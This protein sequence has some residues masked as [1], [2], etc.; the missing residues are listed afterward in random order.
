[1][2][3]QD[4]QWVTST[5]SLCG[6]WC[7]S[8]IFSSKCI[9]GANNNVGVMLH[10]SSL[11]RMRNVIYKVKWDY[12]FHLLS[13]WFVLASGFL[14]RCMQIQMSDASA[15]CQCC[16]LPGS[17]LIQP[18][19]TVLSRNLKWYTLPVPSP[20]SSEWNL[21][22]EWAEHRKATYGFS[23]IYSFRCI[24]PAVRDVATFCCTLPACTKSATCDSKPLLIVWKQLAFLEEVI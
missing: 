21:R 12:S 14:R 20:R 24:G 1:M 11:I 10:S 16:S 4:C 15:R 19:F 9:Q 18:G 13:K 22:S 17:W 23:G 3:K 2:W 6:F 7:N 5:V 8:F